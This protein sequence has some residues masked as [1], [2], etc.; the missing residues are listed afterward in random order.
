MKTSGRYLLRGLLILLLAAALRLGAFDEA[1]IGADQTSI[2][3]GAADIAH[4]VRFPLIGMK[5]SIGVMQPPAT[6]YFAAI[7][8]LLVQRVIAIKFFFSALDLLAIALLYRAVRRTCGPHAAWIAALLYAT[9]PWIVE[10]NR[11]IWYQTLI[12]TFATIS[13]AALL[14]T[15]APQARWRDAWLALGLIAA[16]LMGLVHLVAAIW[17]P[18]LFL[19]AALL[20]VRLRL[21]RGFSAGLMLSL[22]AAYPYLRYLL[23]T[24]G[25]D[26]ALLLSGR[27]ETRTWNTFT[28]RLGYELLGGREVLSTPRDPLWANS[29]YAPN[30]FYSLIPILIGLAAG[31]LLYH[32]IRN[33][34]LSPPQLLL[35]LWTLLA[36]TIF[37]FFSFHLQHYYLLFLFPAPYVLLG[38][39]LQ[40]LHTTNASHR[41]LATSLSLIVI[42]V[43]FWW[44]YLW[45]VRVTFENQGLLRAPT[46]AWLMDAAAESAARYLAATPEAEFVILVDFD[47]EDFSAFDWI[48][49]FIHNERARIAPAG[50]G[51]ILPARS[52][53]YLLGP[54]VD[55][56]T[57]AAPLMEMGAVLRPDLAAVP[58]LPWPIYCTSAPQTI[59]VPVATWQNG[60]NLLN[61]TITG[62][63]HPGSTLTLT[64]SWRYTGNAPTQTYH[65]FNY[66]LY[67]GEL[68]AQIDGRGVPT[69]Y[70]RQGD[71]LFTYFTL[72]LPQT[73]P[74]GTYQLRMG[75]YTWP[76]IEAVLLDDGTTAY[77]VKL[78]EKP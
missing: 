4:G 63:W 72:P 29:V 44:S 5:S 47:G 39:W 8:L 37:L 52:A 12:P 25:A 26:I 31:G 22:G 3:S 58:A 32:W 55:I 61:A 6:L 13:C 69:R 65:F 56:A 24:R 66:L 76:D 27:S 30:A 68:L 7:P 16:T 54:G 73:L 74:P 41:R 51:L 49:A 34:H 17:T 2:L 20:A 45:G 42:G 28:Y 64:Y 19:I 53:C 14:E 15:L 60:L 36:P 11:W 9:N 57:H 23:L 21:W 46:R 38:S 78:W 71:L 75:Q 33:R 59:S 48:P 77:T 62:D 50:E 18:V 1:L 43:A 67:N 70:W 10:F 40:I 35:M